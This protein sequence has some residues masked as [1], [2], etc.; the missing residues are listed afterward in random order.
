MASGAAAK[1]RMAIVAA[2]ILLVLLS[3]REPHVMATDDDAC[4]IACRSPCTSFADGF[5]AGA[6]GK[7]CPPAAALVCRDMVFQV[8]AN[9]CYDACIAGTIASCG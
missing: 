7:L 6:S 9:P 3:M 5:C 4:T 1:F 2:C 8:C